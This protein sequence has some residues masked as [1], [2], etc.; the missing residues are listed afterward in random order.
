[1]YTA[2]RLKVIEWE[3]SPSYQCWYREIRPV[4][5]QCNGRLYKYI[6][7]Y[8]DDKVTDLE[9]SKISDL[10]SKPGFLTYDW[11]N[12]I[13]CKCSGQITYCVEEDHW[14]P[15]RYQLIHFKKNKDYHKLWLADI[16]SVLA[17]RYASYETAEITKYKEKLERLEN[18]K[19]DLK[20]YLRAS[21]RRREKGK[22]YAAI[23]SSLVKLKKR[24]GGIEKED[25]DRLRPSN[26]LRKLYH[27]LWCPVNLT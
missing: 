21:E 27:E 26:K 1:M 22:Q 20:R 10:D 16:Y 17:H 9:A 8:C 23:R 15:K 14:L 6:L 18:K 12:H 24:K 4:L 2:S 19:K 7:K 3:H 11:C 13:K 5:R 25:V